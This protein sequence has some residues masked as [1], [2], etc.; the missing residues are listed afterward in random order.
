LSG[1]ITITL[2]AGAAAVTC[3]I[4]ATSSSAT[5]A[6]SVQVAALQAGIGNKLDKPSGA[7]VVKV[8]SSGN[9]SAV[10]GSPGDCV[11]VN[12]TSGACG[13]GGS[14]GGVTLP[15]TAGILKGD[16]AGGA[17]VAVKGTDYQAAAAG[18][19]SSGHMTGMNAT[20]G[21]PI[22]TPDSGGG[23]GGGAG[24]FTIGISSGSGTI[25]CPGGDTCGNQDGPSAYSFSGY[26]GSFTPSATAGHFGSYTAF[27]CLDGNAIKI[28]H[29][30]TMSTSSG[31]TLVSGA[32]A[33]P[34]GMVILASYAVDD[35][36]G[37]TGA[38]LINP[39]YVQPTRYSFPGATVTGT[40][41][42]TVA[43]VP[44]KKLSSPL[45]PGSGAAGVLTTT[46]LTFPHIISNDGTA[47]TLTEAT[48]YSDAGSQTI[49]LKVGSTTLFSITC[50]VTPNRTVTD[51]SAGYIVTGSMAVSTVA[52][53]AS[54]D[55]SGTAN[56]TTKN[57]TLTIW[58]Q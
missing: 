5:V 17:A 28:A 46:D 55:Q 7:G 9:A 58:G 13:T 34:D 27:A 10:P 37:L 38:T 11:K 31:V 53:G 57:V 51:G 39:R 52:P 8:D 15:T 40:N 32:S 50:V 42:K 24:G 35:S 2:T 16:N 12:G 21:A 47:K 4:G 29:N 1:D 56:G 33:C 43:F 30:G 25:A 3:Y 49:T 6:T 44:V 41:V 23:S 45:T 48:C 54:V 19:C 22:C 18:T 36:A 20:T 14:G 26:T